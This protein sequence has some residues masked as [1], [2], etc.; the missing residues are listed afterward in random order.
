MPNLPNPTGS[1]LLVPIQVQALLVNGP[2]QSATVFARWRNNYDNLQEFR[3]PAPG[4]NSNTTEPGP[5]VYLHWKLPTALLRGEA[6]KDSTHIEFKLTPNR[7]VVVRVAQAKAPTPP[8]MTAWLIESDYLG[9]DGTSP[10]ADPNSTPGKV[11]A[12]GLGRHRLLSAWSGE[13]GGELF[14]TATGLADATFTAYQPSVMDVYGFYDD[15]S[16]LPENTVLT[17]WVAGW[18]S[19]PTKDPLAQNSLKDLNWQILPE[20]ATVP[21]WS[22]YHGLTYGLEWQTATEPPRADSQ[23]ASI[24]VAIGYTAIDALAALLAQRTRQPN[25]PAA[26]TQAVEAQLTAFQYNL[27]QTLDEPDGAEQL[28]LKRRQAWFGTTPGGTVWDMVAVD[29][30]RTTPGLDPFA[31]P[32]NRGAAPPPPPLTQAQAQ[33]LAEL[34]QRQRQLDQMQRELA[35]LQWELFAVWWK[36]KNLHYNKNFAAEEKTQKELGILLSQIKAMLEAALNADQPDSL[37]RQVLNQQENIQQLI[38]QVPEPTSPASLQAW[39]NK[40]PDNLSGALAVKPRALPPFF[41]PTD[42]VLLIAGLTPPL[43]GADDNRPLTCRLL[44]ATVTGVTTK[45]GLVT[46]ADLAGVIPIPTSPHFHPQLAAAISALATEAFFADPHN[47][48]TIMQRKWGAADAPTVQALQDAMVNR[49]AH[50][51]AMPLTAPIPPEMTFAFAHWQ[52]VWAPLFLE[53]EITW[54]PCTSDTAVGEAGPKKQARTRDKPQGAKDNWAFDPTA[55]VFKGDGQVA[56]RGHEYYTWTGPLNEKGRRY[57]GRSFLTPQTFALFGRRL[58]NLHSVAKAQYPAYLSQLEALSAQLNETYFLS[59]ALS[60][61]NDAFIMRRL[62]Y[63]VLPDA[64]DPVAAAIGPAMQG[65]PETAGGDQSLHFGGGMPFFFPLR[66]GFFQFNTLR[67]VDAF[68]QTLNLLNQAAVSALVYGAGLKPEADD[69]AKPLERRIKQAPRV[70]QP[71]RLNFRW[72]DAQSEAKELDFSAD[73]NPIC[74][75]LLLNYLN[76]SLVI[77][78]AAGSP[79]GELLQLETETGPSVQWL[80]APAVPDSPAPN[81]NPHLDAMLKIFTASEAEGGL[82]QAARCQAFRALY[83]SIDTTL[84]TIDPPGADNDADLAALIGRPLAL[85]RAQL[86]FEL[87]GHPVTNQS[88]RDTLLGQT[89]AFTDIPFPIQLGNASLLEDGLVGYFIGS[90][91]QTFNVVEA[92]QTTSPYIRTIGQSNTLVALSFSAKPQNL[93]L[94]LDPRG[95]IHA[96]T[97]ILPTV[98]LSLP[99]HLFEAALAQ[100]AVTFRVGP[101][102]TDPA[103]VHLPLPLEHQGSWGWI[104]GTKAAQAA[105]EKVVATDVSDTNAQFPAT[106]PHLVDGWLK[107][108]PSPPDAAPPIPP[109]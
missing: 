13:V 19:D 59:Q 108:S 3:D 46:Q 84:T 29:Q 96:T 105:L 37:L 66:G 35:T 40:I 85:A 39:S 12:K 81:K 103:A 14:L 64:K 92:A 42:P 83:A 75:W 23:A 89:A 45:H 49:T 102:L 32:L 70:V 30:N 26:E 10:F 28:A 91:Y 80:S 60:G 82:P 106:P 93:T 72:L 74:G 50:V 58:H 109:K 15:T 9:T 69:E 22:V 61:F 54:L 52:Q 1:P 6:K 78:D 63:S 33:W 21:T 36:Q 87:Y 86:Q 90:D 76:H 17:Y 65:V 104:A 48:A 67:I 31:V 98:R 97:G 62:S 71:S 73:V 34:N 11:T 5:G 77:Y 25:T 51:A 68:G 99:A 4:L 38:A 88:W 95:S 24:Q 56:E 55:W 57:I 79:L 94:L 44:T 41:H 7:W 16:Q 53:W 100:L 27:L 107:F 8:Q 47:A 101:L 2:V 20:A 18:Y 43:K